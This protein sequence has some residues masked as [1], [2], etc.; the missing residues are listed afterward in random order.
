MKITYYV[1]ASQD[2]FIARD[3]GDVSW[4]DDLNIDVKE[5]G[6]EEFFASIDGLIMG[7][8]T[9]DFVFDYG[10]W[11]YED[12]PSWV[13]TSRDLEVLDG[14][15]L[16]IAG[17]AEQ[18]VSEARAQG[19]KHLWLLGGGRL[20]SSFLEKHLLTDISISEMPIKLISGIPLFA[21]HQLEDLVVRT[22]EETQKNGFKQIDIVLNH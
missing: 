8:K 5:T 13:C 22:N 15:N 1:A 10:S 3:D 7:R 14:A 17:T 18:V 4:L 16:S 12:K 9:Y 21:E 2:G 19:L 11:P 6:L 20:A